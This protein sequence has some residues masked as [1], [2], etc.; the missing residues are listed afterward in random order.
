M[1]VHKRIPSFFTCSKNSCVENTHDVIQGAMSSPCLISSY[2][3]QIFNVFMY[4]E[5]GNDNNHYFVV[6]L[7]YLFDFK[8]NKRDHYDL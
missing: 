4:L 7:C 5:W 6:K 3:F 1:F 8:V 2:L